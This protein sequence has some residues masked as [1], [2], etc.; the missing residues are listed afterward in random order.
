[1]RVRPQSSVGAQKKHQKDNAS[2]SDIIH[3]LQGSLTTYTTVVKI[4][5]VLNGT[6]P[7]VASETE[8]SCRITKRSMNRAPMIALGSRFIPPRGPLFGKTAFTL[9]EVVIAIGLVGF[10][11]TAILGLAVI[12]TNETKNADLKAR[13]TS[14]TQRV[15]AECQS[16]RFPLILESLPATNYWDYSG[17][18]VTDTTDA[19]FRCVVSNVTPPASGNFTRNHLALLQVSIQWPHPSLTSTNASVI[20]LFNYH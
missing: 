14:I 1:M 4:R 10:V 17:T 15:T 18:P 5:F 16:R 9:I 20:S 3:S 12:A 19:Y 7:R 8:R 11:L 2:Q 6:T 13:L